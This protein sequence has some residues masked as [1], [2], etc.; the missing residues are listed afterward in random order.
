MH[1]MRPVAL[2]L[3]L[4]PALAAAEPPSYAQGRARREE[5]SGRV[6]WV[7]VRLGGLYA[8]NSPRGNTPGAGGGGV[9][10][11]FDGGQFLAD[12][13]L[14]G[15]FGD[16]AR[17]LAAG[18]GAY[19][20]F[21]PGNVTPYLGAG[22]KVGYTRFGGDGVFGMIP[23][24]AGGIVVGREGFVQFRTELAWWVA[25]AREAD[26]GGGGGTRSHGPLAT[27]GLAF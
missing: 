10:A 18:L 9:Y 26:R 23:F 5:A 15:A 11:L 21:L 14:D 13:A 25:A 17:F 7:G 4:L 12:V 27:I 24:A 22:L 1:R 2:A 20:P 6:P 16:D 8:V 3:L 19:Y